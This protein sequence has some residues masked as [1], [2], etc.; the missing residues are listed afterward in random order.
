M[1]DTEGNRWNAVI[2]PAHIFNR[3]GT[4]LGLI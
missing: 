3:S 2:R 4:P 1:S